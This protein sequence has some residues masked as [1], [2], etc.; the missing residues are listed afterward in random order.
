MMN[1]E[2]SGSDLRHRDADVHPKSSAHSMT[3]RLDSM[4]NLLVPTR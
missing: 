2:T 1:G 4:V 3:V